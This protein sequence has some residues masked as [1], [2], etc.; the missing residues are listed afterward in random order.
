MKSP[1]LILLII[2]NVLFTSFHAIAQNASLDSLKTQLTH[3]HHDSS[4][5]SIFLKISQLF[6]F[7]QP[8][9]AITY[10]DKALHLVNNHSYN[11]ITAQAYRQIGIGH[12]VKS[13]YKI[14]LINF[15]LSI[16]AWN[17]INYQQNVASAYVNMGNCFQ[18]LALGDSAIDAYLKALSIYEKLDY[19]TGIA[20]ACNGVGLV[21]EEKEDW[22]QALKYYQRALD[23]REKHGPENRLFHSYN[24][25]G[26]VYEKQDS[27][28]LAFE[29]QQKA[30]ANSQ[31]FNHGP[32]ISTAYSTLGNIF[33]KK[34]EL[35]KAEEHY[36]KALEGYL[37]RGEKYFIGFVYNNLAKTSQASG[38]TSNTIKF[39][40]KCIDIALEIN[41]FSLLAEA[42]KLQTE[43]YVY[44]QDYERAFQ[45][46]TSYQSFNDSLQNKAQQE[47]IA[48]L[49]AQYE[50]TRLSREN[51]LKKEELAREQQLRTGMIIGTI[52]VLI[53]LFALFF[54]YKS[55]QGARKKA[56][57]LELQLQANKA[58]R[59]EE[60]DRIK[61]HFFANISHEFRTPLTLILGPINRFIS[62]GFQPKDQTYFHLIKRNGERLLNLINQLLDLSK[63]ESGKIS[64]VF[65]EGDII[66]FLKSLAYSF[67]SLAEEKLISYQM[68]FPSYPIYTHFDKDKLEKIITNLLSN[69]FKYTPE[70]GSV[71]LRIEARGVRGEVLG[72][73]NEVSDEGKTNALSS[74]SS[75]LITIKDTGIGIS[76]EQLPHIFDR[77]YQVKSS[78]FVGTGIGLALTKELVNLYSGNI[79]VESKAEMGSIFKVSIPIEL[80]GEHSIVFTP[81][82]LETQMIAQGQQPALETPPAIQS[83]ERPILLITEDH[84]DVR[85]FIKDGLQEEYHIIEAE[86]G[87]IAWNLATKELPDLIISDIMMPEMDG[88]ELAR[89]LKQDERT[90]HIPLI[91]LT[92]KGS[93]ESKIEGLQIGADD[94]LPKPFNE[95]ELHIRIRN[96]IEQ[97]KKLREV[98]SQELKLGPKTLKLNSVDEKF[99]Q[100]VNATIEEYL[101]NEH[102]GVEDLSREMNMSR[103]QLH[104]K[105]K[106]LIDK[107]PSS[108]IRTF[109]LQYAQNLIEQN[110]ATI[111]EISYMAG[112]SSPAYFS[113]CYKDHFGNTP[114]AKRGLV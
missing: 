94:Y 98:Y 78:E 12:A 91:L 99:M 7:Q 60:I 68:S 48:K 22:P 88:I 76:E 8:D 24:R 47:V 72:V 57:E 9:S 110:V 10:A 30:L 67:H 77:F 64:L 28:D 65:E 49:E 89:K 66:A 3:A 113:K 37:K 54:S 87:L 34:K 85:A 107:T 35:K 75:L 33:L 95:Q 102:F 82:P 106:A 46:Q 86:N 108:L 61:S 103:S 105:L 51:Q 19:A 104:R 21:Y 14:A 101:S 84:Q 109:R 6:L 43:A 23:L 29:Y 79:E 58:Q 90:S 45:A 93:T 62:Q 73:S 55:R 44:Q 70:G 42:Y 71:E 52:A 92:A 63:L 114:G 96:L 17:A 18:R 100:K 97:R 69:A 59:L 81:E 2:S 31:Q 38:N 15:R 25:L 39:T 26:N 27:L 36:Q 32:G 111:S 5:A 13:N 50:N 1:L 40:K 11:T 80:S 16:E 4:R 74:D 83:T 112:F 53:F 20:A 41:S 56:A